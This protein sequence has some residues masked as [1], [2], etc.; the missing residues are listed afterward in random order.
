[1]QRDANGVPQ[2][3]ADT[4]EDLFTAQGYVQAQD[5]FYEMDVR[6]HMTSGRLSEMF[7]A[8]QV[9]NDAFLRT[10]GWHQVAQ[11]EYDTELSPDHEA[12]P[13]G[14]RGRRQRLPRR[15]PTARRIS[16]GVRGAR[17]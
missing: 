7:G 17:A 5:R 1:M 2:I 15:A 6:R 9:E 11:Q 16:P 13:A 10:L 12:V 14:V 4:A 3:Y 8:G